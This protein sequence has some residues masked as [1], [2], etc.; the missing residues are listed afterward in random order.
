MN[1]SPSSETTAIGFIGLGIMG[2]SM[3]A[4]L[5]KAGH[6][7]HLHTRTRAKAGPLVEAGAQWHDSAGSVARAADI[8]ITIVG[9]PEDV[10]AVYFGPHGLL[11]NAA[12]GAVLIDMTTSSPVLAKRIH[13]EGRDREIGC[14]DAPVSGGDIGAREARLSIMVGGDEEDYQRA[15]P[16]L[17]CMGSNIVHLGPAGCGQHT[18]MANQIAIA[19]NMMGVCEA[20]AYAQAAGLDQATVLKSIGSGAAGSWS[21]GNLGPRIIGGDF[22]PGFMVKHLIKDLKIALESAREMGLE[23]P[24][25]KLA[26]SLYEY[27]ATQGCAD[28]GTQVLYQLY[29]TNIHP[30]RG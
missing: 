29:D 8:I 5:M 14:L 18:K 9:M 30:R 15:L 25:I 4:N 22:A 16:V 1:K 11:E 27:L 6:A 17:Q 10:E 20:L 3:A 24:G 13:A 2:R 7:L 28:C 26:T 23:A 19:S 12:K 21:L